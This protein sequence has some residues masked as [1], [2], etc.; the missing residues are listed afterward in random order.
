MPP[1][2]NRGESHVRSQL[3]TSTMWFLF[4][5]LS[6]SSFPRFD[7]I[8]CST[9]PLHPQLHLPTLLR[10]TASILRALHLVCEKPDLR[11]NCPPPNL[12]E[13]SSWKAL[14][15][16]Q[17]SPQSLNLTEQDNKPGEHCQVNSKLSASF[18]QVKRLDS[19][20]S[21]PAKWIQNKTRT[22]ILLFTSV[23]PQ[24]I[25]FQ[26]FCLLFRVLKT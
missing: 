18:V 11:W 13:S 4:V 8:A 6:F 19:S 3:S 2:A 16:S 26:V 25:W 9:P 5:S 22:Q 20:C 21:S 7:L 14:P 10:G 17:G 23:F 1:F 24:T 15:Q 12:T